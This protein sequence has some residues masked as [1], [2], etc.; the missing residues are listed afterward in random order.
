MKISLCFLSLLHKTVLE[1]TKVVVLK[2]LQMTRETE[3]HPPTWLSLPKVNDSLETQPKINSQ[4]TLKIQSLMQ[5]EWLVGHGT[6]LQC[7]KTWNT[8]PS[9]QRKRTTNP[10]S[11]W[12]WRERIDCL[13]QRKSALWC[14]Q[15][16]RYGKHKSVVNLH[17]KRLCESTKLVYICLAFPVSVFHCLLLSSPPPTCLGNCWSLSWSLGNTRSCDGAGLLQW[18]TATGH[19]GCWHYCWLECHEDH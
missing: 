17:W 15:R 9:W 19:Q 1:S 4:Q 7:S 3:S 18:R 16:W 2:S 10:T 12:L 8:S 11:K 5:N 14:S 6:I 13:L